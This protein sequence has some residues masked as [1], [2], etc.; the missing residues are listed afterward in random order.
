MGLR[1]LHAGLINPNRAILT[2]GPQ[3]SS[4]S[5]WKHERVATLDSLIRSLGNYPDMVARALPRKTKDKLSCVI[6][7]G[8][9]TT[10]TRG[11]TA[12]HYSFIF[13]IVVASRYHKYIKYSHP[14][15]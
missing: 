12:L 1:K 11:K 5:S 9:F 10:L 3:I 8:L 2:S 14:S 4:G 13:I 6:G 7:K 15:I